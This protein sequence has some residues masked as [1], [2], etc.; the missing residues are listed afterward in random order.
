MALL[1]FD[2]GLDPFRALLSLQDELARFMRNPA[3]AMGPSGFGA[4]PPV[5]IFDSP[6]GAL[7]VAEV[8]GLN[9]AKLNL[10]GAGRT[11]TISG[12]REF[13]PDGDGRGII[14]AN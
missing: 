5:N 7:I 8:P 12:E 4:Y 3:F 10:I 6:E 14:A 1:R 2:S 11:L 9:M 13:K